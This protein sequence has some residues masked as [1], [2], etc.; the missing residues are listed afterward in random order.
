MKAAVIY[1]PEDI[2]IEERQIPKPEHNEVLI[3]IHACGVCGTDDA[4]NRGEY[5]GAYPVIIGHEF[6]GEVVETGGSVRNIS[7]GDRVTADPNRVCH[8]CYFCRCGQEHLCD[9]LRSMGV[10][11]DGANAEYCVMTEDNVYRIGNTLSYEEAAF[12]EP[13]ACAIHGTDLAQVKVGDTVLVVGAGGMGNLITQC[14]RNSGAANIIVSE[15][16]AY[17][18]EKALENGASHV[19]DP[20]TC[21]VAAE[22]RKIQEVGADIVIEVAGNSKAQ[23]LCPTYLRKGGTLVY[24]GC[25]PKDNLIEINPF[26]INENEQRILGSFNNK[27]STARAVEMLSLGRIRVDNLVSHRFSLNEYLDVFTCFGRSDTIKLMVNMN[28]PGSGKQG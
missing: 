5:P 7:V 9:N 24:F 13:L 18:R 6:S 19:L 28:S 17:R 22:V 11:I 20:G 16:I 4:L 27:A 23:A 2:R 12:S 26:L 25:S 10:H 1:G 21:D 15:P 8:N 14:V 3:R